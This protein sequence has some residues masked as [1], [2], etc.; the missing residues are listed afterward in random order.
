LFGAQCGLAGLPH[1]S[2]HGLRKAC[3]RRLAEAECAPHQIKA[4]TGHVT[5]TEVER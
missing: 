3:A 2:A 1:C 5:L 4:I